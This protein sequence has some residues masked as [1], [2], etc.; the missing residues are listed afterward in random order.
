ML[1]P[2]LLTRPRHAWPRAVPAV[3]PS[4]LRSAV[5]IGI[6]GSGFCFFHCLMRRLL[7]SQ[8]ML[9]SAAMPGLLAALL[10]LPVEDPR[11]HADLAVYCASHAASVLWNAAAELGLV[12]AAA[13]SR[14]V[15]VAATVAALAV[16]LTGHLHAPDCIPHSIRPALC[17]LAGPARPPAGAATGDGASARTGNT[18]R[19]RTGWLRQLGRLVLALSRLSGAAALGL[20]PA[21]IA[22]AASRFA[23]GFLM[24]ALLLVLAAAAPHAL[25]G[26]AAAAVAAARKAASRPGFALALAWL[27]GAFPLCRVALGCRDS[28][29]AQDAAGIATTAVAA[30][31]AGIGLVWSPLPTEIA[32]VLLSKAIESLYRH[33]MHRGLLPSWKHGSLSLFAASCALLTHAAFYAAHWL[34][35]SYWNFLMLATDGLLRTI[36]R[37]AMCAFGT[38]SIE[39]FRRG[40]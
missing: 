39:C 28:P 8:R 21:I 2:V 30:A 12:P 13:A 35:P 18:G 11:R 9:A 32:M 29:R 24:A 4:I 3:L 6:Y 10:A 33:G 22:A 16:L 23:R 25:R 7:G 20:E 5:F 31:V 17:F 38:R 34:R 1:L 15:A 27:M 19:S 40:L 37:E 26:R 14:P 36:N